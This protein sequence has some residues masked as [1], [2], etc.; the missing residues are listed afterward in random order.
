MDLAKQA[1]EWVFGHPHDAAIWINGAAVFLAA[2]A[3]VI[4]VAFSTCVPPWHKAYFHFWVMVLCL[5]SWVLNVD[6]A[7]AFTDWNSNLFWIG[8]VSGFVVLIIGLIKGM[9]KH[10]AESRTPAR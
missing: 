4:T 7:P 5:R 6:R 2:I 10:D 1:L 9:I 3:F 8:A